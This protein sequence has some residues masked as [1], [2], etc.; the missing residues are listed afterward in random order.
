MNIPLTIQEKAGLFDRLHEFHLAKGFTIEKF[1]EFADNLF[2]DNCHK[3]DGRC[4]IC[5]EPNH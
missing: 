4:Q 3:D 5:G 2:T 1:A